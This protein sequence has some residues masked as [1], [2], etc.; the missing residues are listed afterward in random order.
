M[1]ALSR[2]VTRHRV[3]AKRKGVDAGLSKAA[4]TVR[5]VSFA[6]TG[7]HPLVPLGELLVGSLGA[8]RV[9]LGVRFVPGFP[10]VDHGAGVSVD[11]AALHLR[12]D[13]SGALVVTA[14]TRGAIHR[15][16]LIPVAALPLT[17][18]DLSQR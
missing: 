14:Q 10:A 12:P 3:Q 16:A 13:L 5:I 17:N 2:W 11:N 7:S 1:D 6:S 4:P 15:R 9:G 8:D 18:P